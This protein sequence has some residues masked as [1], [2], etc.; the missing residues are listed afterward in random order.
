MPLAAAFLVAV[1]AALLLT[2]PVRRMAWAVG[3]LDHP[4]ARKLH[5]HATAL[6]GGTVVF[7]SAALGW[8]ASLLLHPGPLQAAPQLWVMGAVVALALG[9]VDDRYGMRPLV[10]LAGQTTAAGVFLWSG[11]APELGLGAPLDTLVCLLYMVTLMNAVNFLDNMDGV[12]TGLAAIAM[13]AFA[14]LAV[15]RGAHGFAACQ[16]ALAG[17]CLGFLRYN[18]RRASIFLGDAGS[19]FLGYSLG[20]SGLLAMQAGPGRW[21]HLGVALILGYPLFDLAFVV[22]DRIRAGRP[23]YQ[24]GRD[25][26][27]HRLA[28]VLKCQKKTVRILYAN[29]AALS[30]SGVGVYAL[31]QPLPALLMWALWSLF[32]LSAGI[33]LSRVPVPPKD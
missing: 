29:G 31:N 10:K 19:L 15:Q 20:A 17:A 11:A 14:W 28:S 13:T 5:T 1:L 12:V 8:G 2:P 3:Y 33:W 7:V 25:H 27:N 9:L 23:I 24:G 4:E 30:A 32:L 26:T 21:A 6:L 22:I 18:L 16:L